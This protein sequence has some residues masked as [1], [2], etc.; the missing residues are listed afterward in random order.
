M[1]SRSGIVGVG[2]A[3]NCGNTSAASCQSRQPSR[4]T[5]VSVL[6]RP[7]ANQ[8]RIRSVEAGPNCPPEGGRTYQTTLPAAASGSTGPR[9]S[10][11]GGGEG[12]GGRREGPPP[13]SL[14]GVGTAADV[15]AAGAARRPG[16]GLLPRLRFLESG[17]G[18][19][20]L[21]RDLH[22]RPAGGA[23]PRLPGLKILDVELVSVGTIEAY[24][25]SVAAPWTAPGIIPP[26]RD[27]YHG[28]GRRQWGWYSE[29]CTAYDVVLAAAM[30]VRGCL[31]AV[32]PQE[33]GNGLLF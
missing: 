11:G 12:H 25:H 22:F 13:E 28:L 29:G 20:A 21:Q 5:R 7:S 2:A 18:A 14:H 26:A 10:V 17:A 15:A 16:F 31:G 32:Q 6:T 8:A 30:V 23:N 9:R 33:D 1:A 24:A 3:D 27:W 4:Q 19:G